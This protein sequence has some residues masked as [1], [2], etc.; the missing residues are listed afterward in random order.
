MFAGIIFLII[1]VPIAILP[2]ALSGLFSAHELSEM[3][4]ASDVSS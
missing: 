3:G 1:F 2:L 4:I